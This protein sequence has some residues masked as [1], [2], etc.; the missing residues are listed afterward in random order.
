MNQYCVVYETKPRPDGFGGNRFYTSY[1]SYQDFQKA[2]L[3]L[4]GSCFIV[5]TSGISQSEAEKLVCQAPDI[6]QVIA[7]LDCLFDPKTGKLIDPTDTASEHTINLQVSK[8][9]FAIKMNHEFQAKYDIE[10]TLE[11]PPNLRDLPLTTPTGITDRMRIVR[12]LRA[13]A[14]TGYLYKNDTEWY[15]KSLFKDMIANF[16][17]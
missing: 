12:A 17:Y 14:P 8:A 3:S 5:D 10:P 2:D 7:V 15:L 9:I 4:D 1:P 11:L 13:S 16:R 6:C